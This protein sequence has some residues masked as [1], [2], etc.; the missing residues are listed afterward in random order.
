MEIQRGFRDKLENHLNLNQPFDVEMITLGGAVYDCCCFGVDANNKLSD[1]RYMIFY[2]Q[3]SSPNDEIKLVNSGSNAKFVL[4]LSKLPGSINKLVFTVSID[5]S[6]TI[7]QINSHVLSVS[8]TN[9]SGLRMNLNGSDFHE[10][11]AIISIEIYK[12][13]SWRLAAVA[14][15]F[16]GGLSELLKSYG[17]E[18]I[19]TPTPKPHEENRKPVELRKGQKVNLEKTTSVIGEILINLNWHQGIKKG[20][21]FSKSSSIDLDLGC[22][23]EL[24]DGVK[25]CVQALG[26]S[27]GNLNYPPYISLDGDDR[28]G[29]VEGGENLRVNGAKISEIKRVLIYTF[30]YEGAANWQEA[31]GVVTVKCPNSRDIIV[32]MD[33][34]SSRQTMCAI[35]MLE[36]VNNETFSVEKLV[37]FFD[38]HVDMDR[39]YNWGLRWVHGSKD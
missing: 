20:F 37:K 21:L 34:Y 8:Q 13:D 32:K 33:E 27:F 26:N 4:D 16:N 25:G 1:D 35:A 14:S 5:G 30:I 24:T 29:A 38:G 9:S 17:G 2:N 31:D 18:E 19:T 11:K 28:T 39:Y 6:G 10:E 22:L 3:T 36:N 7:G 23:F 15:G 12:K